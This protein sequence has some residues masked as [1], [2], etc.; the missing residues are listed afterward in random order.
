MRT[1]QGS[2]A[3]QRDFALAVPLCAVA[4]L[5]T[6]PNVPTGYLLALAGLGLAS[7]W[8]VRAY[9]NDEPARKLVP[10]LDRG[11]QGRASEHPW[12]DR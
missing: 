1:F 7:A 8:T 3:I 5:F 4:W 12:S 11:G 2:T 10:L 6:T 9:L